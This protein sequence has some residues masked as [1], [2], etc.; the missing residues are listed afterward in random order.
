MQSK[1]K[2]PMTSIEREHVAKIKEMDCVICNAAG[3]SECH[4]IKQGQWFTSMP[5]CSDCHRGS[6]NGWHGQK[7]MWA[8]KKMDELDALN[9]TIQRLLRMKQEA[10]W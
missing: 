6:F 9:V 3:P 8:V 7:R 2:T 1:N 5:L 4:E 10:G